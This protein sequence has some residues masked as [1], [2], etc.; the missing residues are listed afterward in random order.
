M[1]IEE[2]QDQSLQPEQCAQI[3]EAIKIADIPTELDNQIQVLQRAASEH[4]IRQDE[5][6]KIT[7][8]LRSNLDE[9]MATLLSSLEGITN[10]PVKDNND[11]RSLQE[12]Q[13]EVSSS[14]QTSINHISVALEARSK[15]LQLAMKEHKQ[16]ILAL[17]SF[18]EDKAAMQERALT[19]ENASFD[20]NTSI[21]PTSQWPPATLP[22][23]H[24]AI[25]LLST[26]I[27]SVTALSVMRP[28]QYVQPSSSSL[29]S[30]TSSQAQFAYSEFGNSYS[31]AT[32]QTDTSQS[33]SKQPA[34]TRASAWV[35][36]FSGTTN[37]SPTR[38]TKATFSQS[39]P[40]GR[41]SPREAELPTVPCLPDYLGDNGGTDWSK[42]ISKLD[43]NDSD[44]GG[45]SGTGQHGQ[46]NNTYI[47]NPGP[48][49]LDSSSEYDRYSG[50]FSGGDSGGYSGGCSYSSSDDSTRHNF[51][52]IQH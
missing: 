52:W 21:E 6:L 14:V 43:E 5:Q 42:K 22:T 47:S 40:T 37:Q 16:L 49:I 34:E 35:S 23:A 44:L 32:A 25:A 28:G 8:D 29:S 11:T 45:N 3:V 12:S 9:K 31:P 26:V 1:S 33:S 18:L 13:L 38:Q 51:Y 4:N 7:K 24:L 10:F 48:V 15:E 41:N 36:D 39:T 46:S 17:K 27:S 2:M 30:K 20:P 19:E 50:G